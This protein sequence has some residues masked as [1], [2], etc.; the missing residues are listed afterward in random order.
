MPE[1]L[2]RVQI[3]KPAGGEDLRCFLL[4]VAYFL[5]CAN[6]TG[7]TAEKSQEM[8]AAF[9]NQTLCANTTRVF[10]ALYGRSE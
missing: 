3:L 1:K 6:E 7:R 8:S 5:V 4:T 9:E 10:R 2:F